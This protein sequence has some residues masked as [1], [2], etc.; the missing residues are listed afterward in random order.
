MADAVRLCRPRATFRAEPGRVVVVRAGGK[1]LLFPVAV[2]RLW[3]R[4]LAELADTAER[5]EESAA[6]A[7]SGS[8]TRIRTAAPTRKAGR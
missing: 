6:V 8:V 2:A 4:N 7:D 5:M 3:S 1:R